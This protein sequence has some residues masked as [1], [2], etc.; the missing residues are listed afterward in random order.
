MSNVITATK[1]PITIECIKW[2]GNNFDEVKEFCPTAFMDGD[3]LTI[4]TL[5]GNHQ[6]I[7]GSYI[8]KGVK[9]EF[10][11]CEGNIFLQSYNI[12]EK[13]AN[14]LSDLEYMHDFGWAIQQ[15]KLGKHIQRYG[16]NGKGQ[17]VELATAISYKNPDGTVTNCNHDAIGNKAFAFV[18]T[19]GV[20]IGWVAS[21]ADLLAEDWRVTE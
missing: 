11:P 17:Y 3:I 8:I 9:G 20:Q 5:E 10:Y 12:E 18:G 21:Q 4:P 19:S 7:L 6:A 13:T 15:A 1:K 2:D 14:T 16:W